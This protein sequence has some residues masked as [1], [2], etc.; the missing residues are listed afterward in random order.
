MTNG[1]RA[2]PERDSGRVFNLAVPL[3]VWAAHFLGVY[4]VGAVRCERY[5]SASMPGTQTAIYGMTAIAVA[6]IVLA[7][8]RAWRNRRSARSHPADRSQAGRDQKEFLANT[9]L[10]VCLLAMMAVAWQTLPALLS[11]SCA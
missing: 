7:A 6:C 10:L 9:T 4:V 1:R 5:G 11:A 8:L 2:R 3:L